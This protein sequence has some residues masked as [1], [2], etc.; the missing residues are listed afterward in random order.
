M[1][2]V[3]KKNVYVIYSNTEGYI[4]HNTTKDFE[5]GHTHLNNFK[6]AKFIIDLAIHKSIPHHLCTY[7]LVSLMRI[8][9]DEEYIEKIN[10]LYETKKDRA[11]SKRKL[12][13]MRRRR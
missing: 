11:S 3:Y 8:S 5:N 9:T 2:R 7:F 12:N 13:N 1:V 6:T 4:I 10:S